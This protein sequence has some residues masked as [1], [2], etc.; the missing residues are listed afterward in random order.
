MSANLTTLANTSSILNMSTSSNVFLRENITDIITTLKPSL[1]PF[2]PLK[3][4][5]WLLILAFCVILVSGT[6]GNILVIFV[7]GYKKKSKTRSTTEWLILYLGII[8]LFA[9]IFNPPLFIYWTV[10][11]Y[12]SKWPFGRL[13]CKILPALGPITTSASAGILL[14]FAIDRYMAIV[15]PFAG[16]LNWRTIT[17][18]AVIDVFLSVLSYFHYMYMLILDSNGYCYVPHVERLEYGVPNCLLIILRLLI[19][20]IIFIYTNSRIFIVLRRNEFSSTVTEQRGRRHKQSKRII[21]VLLTMGIVFFILVFPRELFYLVYNMSWIVTYPGLSYNAT[22]LLVNSWLKV[23][24][25]AN[26]CANVF[27]YSHMQ[28]YYRRQI[29]K[30]LH[31]FGCC[32][33]RMERLLFETNQ[34]SMIRGRSSSANTTYVPYH[35]NNTHVNT[36]VTYIHASFFRRMQIYINKSEEVYVDCIDE[37]KPIFAWRPLS[38]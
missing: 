1:K 25:T 13:G 10:T 27:I 9:S 20:L 37:Y 24:H 21:R 28:T 18:A 17:V 2:V 19:F 29:F 3:V 6:L 26:S 11:R 34:A 14:I 32:K 36:H 8:D 4:E 23:F 5:E 15:S 38:I 35:N 16:Q 30:V 31:F 7:F 33:K 12:Q 22:T